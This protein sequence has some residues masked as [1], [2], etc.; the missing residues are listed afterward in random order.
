MDIETNSKVNEIQREKGEKK[1]NKD[2]ELKEVTKSLEKSEDK[3][4]EVKKK[5]NSTYDTSTILGS[6][7][8]YII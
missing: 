7:I 5:D 3:L 8:N 4:K 2:K 6:E 1:E